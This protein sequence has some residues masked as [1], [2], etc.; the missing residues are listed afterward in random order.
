[1]LQVACLGSCL[2]SSALDGIGTCVVALFP[3]ALDAVPGSSFCVVFAVD[4]PCH[5]PGFAHGGCPQLQAHLCGS[6]LF[7]WVTVPGKLSE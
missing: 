6:A 7:L 5:Q 1:M 2:L 4:G 3:A